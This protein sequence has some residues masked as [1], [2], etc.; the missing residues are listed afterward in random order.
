MRAVVYRQNQTKSDIEGDNM[1]KDVQIQ[2]LNRL[3]SGKK[4]S[5]IASELKINRETI[6]Q[7]KK[8]NPEFIAAYNRERNAIVMGLRE[9]MFGLVS[10]AI[11]TLQEKMTPKEA[12][13]ILKLCFENGF[14]EKLSESKDTDEDE[15]TKEMFEEKIKQIV[16]RYRNEGKTKKEVQEILEYERLNGYQKSVFNEKWASYERLF[17]FGNVEI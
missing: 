17:S 8:T 16:R 10:K 5:D 6:W 9:E 15:L 2:A 4:I 3:L 12:M 11:E 7:W 14:S 13:D 1:L